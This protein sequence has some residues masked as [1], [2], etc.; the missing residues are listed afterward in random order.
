MSTLTKRDRWLV[1]SLPA[2]VLFLAGWIFHLR[3]EERELESLRNRIQNQ[4]PLET[5]K[6]AAT[7][8]HLQCGG[9]QK[10][11][12]EKRA[13]RSSSGTFNRNLAIRQVSQLCSTH[14]LSLDDSR[15]DSSSGLPQELRDALPAIDNQQNFTEPQVWRIEMSGEY[16][17]MLGLLEDLN[18]TKTLIVP[19][20]LSMNTDANELLP[21]KWTLTLWL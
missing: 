3:P 20:S 16:V 19:L 9:L 21:A 15:S 18:R 2:L 13:D 1:S 8:A 5:R 6:T 10:L 12:E 17:S 11:I 4:G 14:G 7:M